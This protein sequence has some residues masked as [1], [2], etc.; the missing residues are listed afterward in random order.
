MYVLQATKR[1]AILL[2]KKITC[3]YSQGAPEKVKDNQVAVFVLVGLLQF[4]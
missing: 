4:F 1:H 2:H 3:S